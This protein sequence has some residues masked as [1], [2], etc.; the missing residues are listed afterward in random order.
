MDSEAFKV[1]KK[2]KLGIIPRTVSHIFKQIENNAMK[3]TVY[4]SFMQIYNEEIY[5]M[6][7]NQK[8]NKRLGERGLRIREDT[9]QGTYVEGLTEYIVTDKEQCFELLIKGERIRAK[10]STKLNMQSSRSHTIFQIVIESDEADEK[11]VIKRAKLNIGDLAGSE[12][13]FLDEFPSA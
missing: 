9:V 4:M 5:D 10:R 11:G 8:R 12:K 2:S 13:I 3:C 1:L 6:F 7:G